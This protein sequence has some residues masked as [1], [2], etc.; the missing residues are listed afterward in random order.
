MRLGARKRIRMLIMCLEL[1]ET[2]PKG[3]AYAVGVFHSLRLALGIDVKF[4]IIIII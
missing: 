2:C 1:K 3:H 4:D